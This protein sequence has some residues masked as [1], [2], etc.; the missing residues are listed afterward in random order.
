MKGKLF[1]LILIVFISKSSFSQKTITI[2][3]NKGYYHKE[4]VSVLKS[5]SKILH[6]PY[7]LLTIK[8]VLVSEGF[9]KFGLR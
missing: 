2:E 4:I 1:L 6:G 3:K 5:N 9:Y 8:R 7:K